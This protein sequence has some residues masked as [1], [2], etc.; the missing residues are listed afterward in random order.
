MAESQT[1]TDGATEPNECDV[2]GETYKSPQALGGH[3]SGHSDKER[4]VGVEAGTLPETVPSPE[5]SLGLWGLAQ[6]LAAFPAP[7]Y[8]DVTIHAE[9][10]VIHTSDVGYLALV[11]TSVADVCG[12]AARR[13]CER[14]GFQTT[15]DDT[16][17]D[18][19]V[20]LPV[21]GWDP[22][23]HEIAEDMTCHIEVGEPFPSELDVRGSD[24]L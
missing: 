2:C 15:S 4:A 18:F 1:E 16:P 17:Q 10:D 8:P 23:A 9:S 7:E 13:I 19:Y 11:D 20:G 24:C 22:T 6:I 21:D 3:L 14:R 12:H 5:E